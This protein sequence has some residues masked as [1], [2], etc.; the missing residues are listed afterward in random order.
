MNGIIVPISGGLNQIVAN[1]GSCSVVCND[2]NEISLN[3]RV[4]G[5]TMSD[6]A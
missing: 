4:L 2:N 6:F 3:G 1:D 5:F